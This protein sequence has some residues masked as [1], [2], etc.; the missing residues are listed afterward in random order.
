MPIKW[1]LKT[2]IKE[3]H[4]IYTAKKL[5]EVIEKKTG[6]NISLQNVCNYLSKTPSMLRLETMEILCTA[7]NCKLSDF[8]E[9]NPSKKKNIMNKKLSFKNTPH[10][11]RGVDN[12][13][14]PKEYQ[15]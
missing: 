9:I 7:L 14:D 5:K 1:K 10:T 11:K 4:S 8:V 15:S 6:V 12:F 3:N 2:Y 13:P